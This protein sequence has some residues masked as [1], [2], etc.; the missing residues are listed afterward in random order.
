MLVENS[1]ADRVFFA[2]SGAEANEGAFK[3]ARLYFRKKG[4]AHRYEII[5]LERSFHGRTLATIAA[6]GQEKYRKNWTPL[7][8]RFSSVPMNNIAAL[9]SAIS[10]NT[11]AVLLEPV[12]GESGVHPADL[13]YMRQVRALCDKTGTLLILDE[14][15]TGLGRTGKLFGYQHYGVEPDIFTLAKALGGGVPI[16]A[17]LARESVAQA[18]EPGDHGSTFGGNPL[19]CAAGLA[20]LSTL[21]EDNLVE[22]SAR[23]GDYL[24]KCLGEIRSRKPILSELRGL[25]LMVGIQLAEPL[26]KDL[27]RRCLE[28]G[29]LVGT[30]G[31]DVLRL[32]P[33]LIIRQEDIDRFLTDFEAM[34]PDAGI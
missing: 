28:A 17:V 23:M 21:L 18:F 32:L 10:E 12:Q 24:M 26:A 22:N 11:C 20:T 25:G 27:S 6:T 9:E 1:C 31:D 34:L 29:Y 30:V 15:Q 13:D 2:N 3:L 8:P 7:T 33:P 4:E 14:I 19:A 16:G 5:S